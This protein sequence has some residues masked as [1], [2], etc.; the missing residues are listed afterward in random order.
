MADLNRDPQSM[1]PGGHTEPI[2]RY[3]GREPLE[4][5]LQITVGQK[6]E[7][8]I[9]LRVDEI[10]FHIQKDGYVPPLTPEM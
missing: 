2:A 5:G 3:E 1:S 8:W 7:K 9:V 10:V 4:A 6:N